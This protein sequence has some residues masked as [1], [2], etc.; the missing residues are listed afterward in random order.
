MPYA[1]TIISLNI[2]PQNEPLFILPK[3]SSSK[4]RGLPFQKYFWS[5]KATEMYKIKDVC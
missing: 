3:V 1:F 2:Y 5:G 4:T